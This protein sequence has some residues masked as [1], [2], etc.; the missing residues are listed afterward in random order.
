MLRRTSSLLGATSR[1]NEGDKD[2]TEV[3]DGRASCCIVVMMLWD[4]LY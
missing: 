4:R 2:E 3:D 1:R